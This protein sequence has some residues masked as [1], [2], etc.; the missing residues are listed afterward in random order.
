MP[1]GES[2]RAAVLR[3]AIHCV[4]NIP[5]AVGAE[6]RSGNERSERVGVRAG[7]VE[8]HGRGL[9]LGGGRQERRREP[10]P[11]D[12]GRTRGARTGSSSVHNYCLVVQ[13]PRSWT[14]LSSLPSNWILRVRSAAPPPASSP[15]R[16]AP[17]SSSSREVPL[18][19]RIDERDGTRGRPSGT[20][21]TR[22]FS[23]RYTRTAR[24]HPALVRLPRFCAILRR[25]TS[26]DI[27]SREPV[28]VGTG[29][30]R[31]REGHVDTGYT[32]GE[33]PNKKVHPDA[34]W[35]TRDREFPR[36]S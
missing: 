31:K 11:P 19:A 29:A 34:P 23:G 4:I 21:E 22:R 10:L 6:T 1:R 24:S 8:P 28:P 27:I 16:P 12:K 33:T 14:L 36:V 35:A 32:E 20:A 18:A 5:F 13:H 7:R 26:Y 9:P 15:V 3:Q 25:F 30:G 2:R 17:L